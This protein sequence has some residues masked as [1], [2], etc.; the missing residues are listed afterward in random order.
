MRIEPL[1]PGSGIIFESEITGSTL[2]R[3]YFKSIEAGYREA[4]QS[5]F[6]AG[7]PVVDVKAVLTD[8]SHHEVDSSEMAFKV[9]ASMAFKSAMSKA[10][11]VI[12][13]PVMR[14][15]V[16]TPSQFLGDVIGDLNSRRALVQN[17]ETRSDIQVVDAFIPLAETFQYATRLRSLTTGRA[18]FSMEIDHYAR[19]PSK[20]VEKV[21][22]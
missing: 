4:A 11:A 1:D 21:A 15:E 9:A 10:N 12:L 2:P 6:I 5:G 3:E 7:Y 13:E 14:I 18:G 20:L 8:G 22:K 16:I 17:T 19:V